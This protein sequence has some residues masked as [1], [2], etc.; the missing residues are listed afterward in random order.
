M[1]LLGSYIQFGGSKI[2]TEKTTK[3]TAINISEIK[4]DQEMG[5]NVK[6]FN[7]RKQGIA[8]D[9]LDI[10]MN[11]N[12]RPGAEH[13]RVPRHIVEPIRVPRHVL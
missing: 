3:K 6:D 5:V 11:S 2:N 4:G 12:V 13:R 1:R 9:E 8:P 7:S 10:Q